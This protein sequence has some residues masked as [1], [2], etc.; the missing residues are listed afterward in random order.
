MEYI[1]E[2]K[3]IEYKQ[4]YSK[5]ILKTVCAYANFHDGLIVVGIKDNGDVIGVDDIEEL[6]LNI[7]NAIN[8][9][10]IPNPYYELNID[11]VNKK[12]L[13]VI[14]VYKGD[15]TPYIYQGKSY[16][17]RDTSTIPADVIAHQN[18]ILAG[19][20]IGYEDLVSPFQYLSF[21]HL[22][23]MMKREYQISSL[24]ED[25]LKTLGLI[26]KDEYNNAAAL[27]SDY[28]PIEHATIQLIAFNNKGVSGIKDR[29]KI[30]ST[31][32]LKQFELCMTFYEKHINKGEIIENTFRKT[33]EDVPLIAFREAV[34]NLIV[35][36]D[37]SLK[38]ESR[39][40]FFSDR[41]ELVSPGGLPLGMLVEEYV[42]GIL[43]KPRNKLIT[44]IFL[45][46]KLI[47]RLATGVRRIKE[48]YINQSRKPIFRVTDN[49][50]IVI[51]PYID[52]V[53]KHSLKEDDSINMM[54]SGN[55]KLIYEYIKVHPMVKR[56]E[57]QKFIG[58]GK[59]QTIEIINK[60]RSYG[61]IVKSGNGPSTGYKV[62]N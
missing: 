9:S 20:N 14:K 59:T 43:S 26:N 53:R 22:E 28:N 8:D 4:E 24:N 13:L 42:D 29:K 58:L 11:T 62:N 32:L 21:D 33:I 12:N 18:L 55:E 46:V 61:R 51:L 52:E 56:D 54:L 7:K 5:T 44:D 47:E 6:K 10:I 2:T 37:Y 23:M 48:Q 60:L 16:L 38:V 19:R 27:L 57:I 39:I 15:Y 35:H 25:I 30:S 40:E 17:R 36:R 3:T 31:S 34:A 50:V 49:A 1:K 45:R 41:I